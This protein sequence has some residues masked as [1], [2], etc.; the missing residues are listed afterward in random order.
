MVKIPG[1]P[2]CSPTIHMLHQAAAVGPFP[3]IIISFGTGQ[4]L[5]GGREGELMKQMSGEGAPT[6]CMSPG[7]WSF[8]M[9][10]SFHS[11]KVVF[12]TE[13][14][15]MYGL[16]KNIGFPRL[17]PWLM[18][19]IPLT[20]PLSVGQLSCLLVLCQ[21]RSV[22]LAELIIRVLLVRA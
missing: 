12:L 3:I 17:L 5:A 18:N 19:S 11:H 21:P 8:S 2:I 20:T 6:T 13:H 9:S 22:D 1:L 7:D 15:C 16:H 14:I 10:F 4:P